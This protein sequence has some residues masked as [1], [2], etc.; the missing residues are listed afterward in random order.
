MTETI[1]SI[2]PFVRDKRLKLLAV[3]TARRISLFPDVPT[4]AEQGMRGFEVGAG[5]GVMV[6][7]KPPRAVIERLSVEI[8]KAL[9][10]PEV[11]SKLAQQGAEPLGSTPDDYAAYLRSEL[12]R[13][14]RVV[15]QTG[16][17]ME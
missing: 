8:N 6:P 2:A 14:A 7:A 17:T 3:T 4:L 9:Q 11:K 13:W 10:S 15:K 16:I 5:Q 12:A 1:N